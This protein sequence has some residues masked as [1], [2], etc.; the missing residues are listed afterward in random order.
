MAVDFIKIGIYVSLALMFFLLASIVTTKWVWIYKKS[1]TVQTKPSIVT[2]T[3]RYFVKDKARL[4]TAFLGIYGLAQLFIE[5]YLLQT[6]SER[7]HNFSETQVRPTAQRAADDWNAAEA[8]I[9]EPF[10]NG[11]NM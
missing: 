6:V 5:I 3:V 1:T 7:I 9:W 8:N 2:K 10:I 4:I 11:T